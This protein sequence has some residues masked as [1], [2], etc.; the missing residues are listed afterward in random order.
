M[1]PDLLEFCNALTLG[2]SAFAWSLWR[3][4]CY[5]VIKVVDGDTVHLKAYPWERLFSPDKPKYH[6]VRLDGIDTPERKEEGWSEA[7]EALRKRV[8]R[9]L[10][11]VEWKGREKYGRHLA[12]LYRRTF[13]VNQWMVK[14]GYAKIYEEGKSKDAQVLGK[15]G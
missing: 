9:K 5:R 2:S 14:N 11:R 1:N 12:V 13:S 3:L 4:N 7:T 10:A 6:S 8:E 15:R